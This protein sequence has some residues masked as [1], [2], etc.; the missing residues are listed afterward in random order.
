MNKFY[1]RFIEDSEKR[2]AYVLDFQVINPD[3]KDFG[4]VALEKKYPEPKMTINAVCSCI[5]L[6]LNDKSKYYKNEELL[7]RIEL[8]IDYARRNQREDGTFD[9]LSCNFY[10]APDTAFCMWPLIPA[11]RLLTIYGYNE[12]CKRIKEKIYTIMKDAAAGLAIGGFHTPNHRW[13][14][15]SVLL[16][17]YNLF[18]D[19]VLKEKAQMY[20]SE[21]IDFT[22]N[23]EYAERSA[24]YNVVN[25]IAMITIY[26]ETGEEK[27][28]QYVV[29]NLEMM[30]TY[31]EPDGSIF[32]NNSTR[33]DRG[34]KFYP[35][36]YFYLY[37]YIAQK[38][39]NKLFQGIAHKIIADI[40]KRGNELLPDCL[41]RLMLRKELASFELK[42][43]GYPSQY[44]KFY[45]E[46]EILR[47]KKDGIS[48][49]IVKNATKFLFFQSG[50]FVLDMKIGANYCEHRYF[51]IQEWER[52]ENSD[53]LKFKAR[54]WYYL[55]F[56]EAQ[57]TSDWWKMDNAS[58]KKL[59]KKDL[60]IIVT[61]TQVEEG[62]DVNIKAGG[63]DRVPLRVE[64]SIP[65]GSMVDSEALYIEGSAGE[66]IVVRNGYVKVRKNNDM[67]LI[68]PGFGTHQFIEGNFGSEGRSRDGFTI[69]FTDFTD[70]DH[71][72]HIERKAGRRE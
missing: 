18:G 20:L 14:I 56:E 27:Y 66:G 2:A 67:L 40:L 26:E 28:L 22:E 61:V 5:S 42:E 31:F 9:L 8:G 23:G 59:Y 38:Y 15:S 19:E 39:D 58:R 12:D 57:N 35:T 25:N 70:F 7:E 44:K 30:T 43:Y 68:G 50:N 17:F 16:T 6:I 54:A 33:Q 32:T 47:A 55:P 4:A 36:E 71:T 13:A 69:Y 49:S 3:S 48:Y 46:S 45:P 41:G 53:V 65:E 1:K 34:K 21:G 51:K 11:Y 10:A 24:N 60:D 63:C 52:T 62:I 64:I 29:K 72:I 37:L